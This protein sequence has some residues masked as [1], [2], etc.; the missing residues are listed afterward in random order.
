MNFSIGCLLIGAQNINGKVIARGLALEERE[1]VLII[2]KLNDVRDNFIFPQ[3]T[4]GEKYSINLIQVKNHRKKVDLTSKVQSPKKYIIRV[5][6]EAEF[7]NRT[8]FTVKKW[9]NTSGT[10]FLDFKLVRSVSS[11]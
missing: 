1:K 2:K 7:G 9:R 3:K 4:P 11:D 10:Q 6:F 5:Y 8:Y